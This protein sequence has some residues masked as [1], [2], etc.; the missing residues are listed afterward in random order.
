[1]YGPTF[2]EK[3][4]T[5]SYVAPL[6]YF[7]IFAALMIGVAIALGAFFVFLPMATHLRSYVEQAFPEDL[8]ITLAHGEVSINQ[9]QP[10]FVPNHF[11]DSRKYLVIFDGND[12]LTPDV[13]KNS[14]F[15][16]VKKTYILTSSDR[17]RVNEQRMETF[18]S[19]AATTTFTKADLLSTADK[20]QKIIVPGAIIGG[21]L[22]CLFGAF[23]GSVLWTAGHAFYLLVP[24]VLLFALSY[25]RRKPFTFTES[26]IVAAYASIPVAIL[27]IVLAIAFFPYPK[28][29]YTLL[30][31]LI[32]FANSAASQSE[33]VQA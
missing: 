5:S 12:T 4:R 25:V 22:L 23:F 31:V 17:D 6:K 2:Y 1:M 10:Y 3:V 20:I 13:E 8:T 16:I 21:V 14:T 9:P 7:A 15:A 33:S 11:S 24:A 29:A 30:V 26:Y 27:G 19:S 32:A 18:D 28:F